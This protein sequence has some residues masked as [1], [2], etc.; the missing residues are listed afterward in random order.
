MS[1]IVIR[2]VR[3]AAGRAHALA[4]RFAVFVAEQGV[5]Q[6]EEI[7]GRDEGARHLLAL[8]DG[9]RVGTLR[10]RFLDAGRVAKIERV[11][12]LAAARGHQVGTALIEAAL[13]LARAEGASLALLHAQTAALGFYARLGFVAHGSEFEEDRIMHIAMRLDL[14]AEAGRQGEAP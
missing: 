10:M 3:D 7:D 13:G 5:S 1:E 12:V 8:L 2:K 6:A 14:R 11:A 9:R 4:I